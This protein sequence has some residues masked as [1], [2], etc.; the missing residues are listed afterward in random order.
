MSSPPK[1]TYEEHSLVFEL[2]SPLHLGSGEPDGFSDAGVVRDFNGLPGIPGTSLQGLLRAECEEASG[3]RV[4]EEIFGWAGGGGR[5]LPNGEDDLGRGGRLWVS[6]G[7]VHDSHNKPV[8]KRLTAAERDRDDVLRDAARPMLRDHVRLTE[9][10]VAA[11]RGK[12]DELVVSAGHR[13]TVEFRL[14]VPDGDSDGAAHWQYLDNILHDQALRLG[15]K[16]RRG[17]GGLKLV[18]LQRAESITHRDI[19]HDN[20]SADSLWMFGGGAS[21][22]ADSAP[23]SGTRIVWEGNQGRVQPVWIIPGSAIKGALVHRIRFHANRIGR[24]FIG[25]ERQTDIEPWMDELFG[26]MKG[27]TGTP[28]KVFIDDMWIDMPSGPDSKSDPAQY[29]APVQNHVAINPFTGGAKDSA[30]FNDEPLRPNIDSMPLRI[31][32]RGTPTPDA[33][34]ALEAATADLCEGRLALGAHT[35]HGYGVFTKA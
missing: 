34:A 9:R 20:I 3:G 24:N 26:K 28:G 12:F 13:F 32:L 7:R 19:F 31:Q 15:G 29:R 5:K 14:A 25:Q 4:S 30:L 27:D 23:V 16:T 6:W 10:G 1:I 22:S 17:L 2:T 18:G 8:T 11:K 21:D 35:G 33:L